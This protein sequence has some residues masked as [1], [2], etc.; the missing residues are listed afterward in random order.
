MLTRDQTVLPAA[1]ARLFACGMSH[2]GCVLFGVHIDA[3][4][5][6]QLN[7]PF[8]VAVQPCVKLL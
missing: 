6:I 5:R 8:A 1:H 3:T 4:W 2:T 7:C